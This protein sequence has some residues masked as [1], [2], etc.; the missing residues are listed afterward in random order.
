MEPHKRIG[1]YEVLEELGRGGMGR[2]FKV[3]NVI[4]DRIEAMKVLLPDLVGRQ[5]LAARFL[6]EIKVLAALS[7]PHIAGLRTALTADN[8]LIMIME[9]VEGQPLANRLTQGP[10]MASEAINDIDQVLDA[11]SYAH[12]QGVIHRD[13][14]PANMMV[15]PQG[16]LKVTD[17]GIARS[18]NDQTLTATGTT[19]G[20]L[21]YM[22]PE[23]VNGEPT[24][25]RSDLYSVGVSLYEMV[26]GLKPFRADSDFGIMRAHIEMR[27]RPPIELAPGLPAGLNDVILKA[28]A[29]NPVDRFQS[30]DEF[31]AALR[32]VST[33]A[34]APS[35]VP[36]ALVDATIPS[37]AASSPEQTAAR[38]APMPP[39]PT[40]VHP[41]L[42]MALGGVLVIA[43]LIGT[44]FYMR[45]AEAGTERTRT[46]GPAPAAT[47][48]AT[49]AS[50]APAPT[51][52]ALPAASPAPATTASTPEAPAAV[53]PPPSTP[54]REPAAVAPRRT[55][56]LRSAV[57]SAAKAPATKE[58]AQPDAINLDQLEQEL[59]Q[60]SGRVSATNSSL[61]RM[62][63]EQARMGLGLRA[64]MVSH[65]QSMNL[66]FSK[67]QDALAKHDGARAKHYKDLA[68]SD[69][70]A[71]EHFLG[72]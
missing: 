12:A 24:D 23:Q 19:T 56:P 49:V 18:A 27:P 3:R 72:R 42:Y 21:S 44:G 63:Q 48:P 55:V 5:D 7:H 25:P 8:Q 31:R 57:V 60:M 62:S 4:S 67:A 52:E 32:R 29:K 13:I 22:S 43:A 41:G 15:T 46:T 11:L 64:D 38:V 69:L 45:K 10:L 71:L 2:V 70:E 26:T 1:D 65:Q 40:R 20:S 39:P 37:R 50:P 30:A 17:F 35:P 34:V 33:A 54:E 68:V 16:V 28:I 6:R 61:D 51:P 47:A 14:K 9:F 59:D 36:N 53:P 66:N 58:S